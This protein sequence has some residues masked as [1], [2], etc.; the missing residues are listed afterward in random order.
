[1]NKNPLTCFDICCG[2]GIFSL[3]FRNAGF[4]ILGGIDIDNKAIKTVKDNLGRAHWESKS[5]HELSKEIELN[6]KH[7]VFKANL[8]IAGLPCQ[9]FSVAGRSDPDDER[10]FLYKE[11]IKVLKLAKPEFILIENVRGIL[12]EANRPVF[13][14]IK[15][16]LK[17]LGYDV[18]FRLYNAS[19]FG[20]PQ[21]RKRVFIIGSLTVPAEFIFELTQLSETKKTVKEAL[22]GLSSTKEKKSINHVFMEHSPRVIKKIQNISNGGPISYRRLKNDRPSLTIVAGHSALPVHPTQ[23]RTI[24][25]REAAR[26]QGIPDNF[27]FTGSHAGQATQIAN[28]VPVDLSQS[29]AKSILKSKKSYNNL[30]SSLYSKLEKKTSTVIIDK[31]TNTFTTYSK[32]NAIDYPWR[33]LSNPYKILITEILLQRTRRETISKKWKEITTSYSKVNPKFT[34]KSKFKNLLKELGIFNKSTTIDK[35]N[36]KLTIFFENHVPQNFEELISLPGVGTYIASAVRTFAFEKADFPVDT[37]AF[38]FVERFYGFKI[39]RSKDEAL[40]IRAF[41]NTFMPKKKNKK[42]VYGFLDFMGSTC[43]PTS[44]HCNNCPFTHNCSYNIRNSNK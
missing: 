41:F 29:I 5:L 10:N 35:L 31:L 30:H 18:S 9:G 40:K 23:H 44:P 24:S 13:K 19:N 16:E 38:R 7:P 6:K 14:K 4:S 1:M 43:T 33:H 37:N 11:L 20:S 17:K 34:D 2:A 15:A 42:F 22:R 32:K 21:S 8:V 12:S 36:K 27:I 25:N 26:L 3:G 28:A 39:K